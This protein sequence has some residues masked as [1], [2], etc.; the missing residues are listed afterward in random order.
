VGNRAEEVEE[1]ELPFYRLCP[2]FS[3][4]F[5]KINMMIQRLFIKCGVEPNEGLA[6]LSLSILII[7]I[8]FANQL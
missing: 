1:K 8:M 6:L 3:Q 7:Q 5:E 4:L 2:S